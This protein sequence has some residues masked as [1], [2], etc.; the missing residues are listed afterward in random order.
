MKLEELI[1]EVVVIFLTTSAVSVRQEELRYSP[2]MQFH[3]WLKPTQVCCFA[4]KDMFFPLP[5]V[6]FCFAFFVA[7]TGHACLFVYYKDF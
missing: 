6:H 7:F 2:R 5:G 1:Q 3:G 4:E